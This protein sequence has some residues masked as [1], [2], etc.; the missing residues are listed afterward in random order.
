MGLAL[1]RGHSM[2]VL[3]N[4]DGQYSE[5][6]MYLR[7]FKDNNPV[8]NHK[9]QPEGM[10][11]EFKKTKTGLQV[12]IAVPVAALNKMQNGPWNTVRLALA[13]IDADKDGKE[14]NQIWWFPAWNTV[15]TIPGSGTFFKK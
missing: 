13:Y 5:W 4:G 15:N 12:E 6:I 10:I 1:M 2:T 11:S 9:A 7:S 8:Y 14:V 3:N